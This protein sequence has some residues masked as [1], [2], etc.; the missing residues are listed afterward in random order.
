MAVVSVCHITAV[1]AVTR[2]D[3]PARKVAYVAAVAAYIGG[4]II[5]F[6]SKISVIRRSAAIVLCTYRPKRI[7][8]IVVDAITGYFLVIDAVKIVREGRSRGIR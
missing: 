1:A 7:S 6:L 8:M 4:R 5:L 2:P 3:Y